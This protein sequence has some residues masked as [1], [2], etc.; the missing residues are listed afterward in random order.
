MAGA[1]QLFEGVELDRLDGLTLDAWD[2]RG[3]W[4][5]L[6]PSNTEEALRLNVEAKQASDME[7]VRDQVSGYLE[8]YS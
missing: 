6:R 2:S 4:A 3:W 1:E 5:N 8:R 7:Q